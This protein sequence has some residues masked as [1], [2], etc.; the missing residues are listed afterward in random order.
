MERWSASKDLPSS[1][2]ATRFAAERLLFVSKNQNHSILAPQFPRIDDPKYYDEIPSMLPGDRPKGYEDLDLLFSTEARQAIQLGGIQTWQAS[3]LSHYARFSP[4]TVVSGGHQPKDRKSVYSPSIPPPMPSSTS[5]VDLQE[6]PLAITTGEEEIFEIYLRERIQVDETRW[7]PFLRKDRWFNWT[8]DEDLRISKEGKL[9]SVDDPKVWE[10]LCVIIELLQTIL[11]G[12]VAYWSEFQDVFG[13]PPRPDSSVLLSYSTEQKISR[14]RGVPCEWDHILL[15][16][17]EEWRE[18]LIWLLEKAIWGPFNLGYAFGATLKKLKVLGSGWTSDRYPAI[19]TISTEGLF[20]LINSDMT[21]AERCMLQV[22]IA[23]TMVHEIMHAVW[24]LRYK[25]GSYIGD[26]LDPARAGRVPEESFLNGEGAAEIGHCMDQL[27]FGGTLHTHPQAL[28]TPLLPMVAVLK[29]FPSTNLP[30]RR[31]LIVPNSAFLKDDALNI[32]HF[33]PLV[34]VSKMLSESFWQD[35]AYPKKSEN[36]F[37]RNPIFVSETRNDAP[38]PSA[39]IVRALAGLSYSYSDDNV[40]VEQWNE[41]ERCWNSFRDGWYPR[42]LKNWERS[43]W[44]E[45]LLRRMY[46]DFE[47]AFEEKDLITCATI[48]SSFANRVIWNGGKEAFIRYMPIPGRGSRV[49]AWHIVGLFMIASIPVV[50]TRIQRGPQPSGKMGVYM[51]PSKEALAAGRDK[52]VTFDNIPEKGAG[53]PASAEPIKVYD[54]IRGTGEHTNYNQLTCLEIVRST[55]TFITQNKGVV[56]G[57]WLKA[58]TSA[59]KALL[60]DR[61]AISASYPDDHATKWASKW[62]FNFPAYSPARVQWKDNGWK[63]YSEGAT[64]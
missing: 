43:P 28:P 48:A 23:L 6:L 21:L 61:N 14:Q 24:H 32:T 60:A 11:Y 16:T 10:H 58:I 3:V 55:M 25:D 47:M 45:C 19:I 64:S 39:P 40:L 52:W 17:S 53:P 41:K 27:F 50:N 33:V 9:W 35:P 56:H 22:R 4:N 29:E 59:T 1:P 38:R 46:A 37:H 7:L 62:V 57:R 18:R 8:E 12:R 30:V 36:F 63:A 15:H 44:S 31:T 51:V 42:E 20:N 26:N 2:W 34:W 54:W 5:S 49:W 13:I